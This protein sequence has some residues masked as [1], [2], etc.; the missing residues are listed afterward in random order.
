MFCFWTYTSKI[1]E[2]L[3]PPLLEPQNG[4][5]HEFCDFIRDCLQKDMT[6]RPKFKD[7]LVRVPIFTIDS[8]T[9]ISLPLFQTTFNVWIPDTLNFYLATFDRL[10]RLLFRYFN[11]PFFGENGDGSELIKTLIKYILLNTYFTF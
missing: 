11:M 2:Y 4:F 9:L 1:R 6:G 7:L 8:T 5:S 10:C 3:Q